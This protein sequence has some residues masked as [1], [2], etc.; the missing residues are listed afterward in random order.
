MTSHCGTRQPQKGIHTA[1]VWS[2]THAFVSWLC[3]MFHFRYVHTNL[4]A[5]F[6]YIFKFIDCCFW[7]HV[8]APVFGSSVTFRE[9]TM[10]KLIF[11]YP[12]VIDYVAFF[13]IPAKISRWQSSRMERWTAVRTPYRSCLRAGIWYGQLGHV[14]G[15]TSL[16]SI[17]RLKKKKIDLG[18]NHRCLCFEKVGGGKFQED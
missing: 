16:I 8:A 14:S 15:D 10:F 11:K 17:H 5:V 13:R 6:I 7:C 4:K 12:F 1:A 2:V 3:S 18:I 9:S